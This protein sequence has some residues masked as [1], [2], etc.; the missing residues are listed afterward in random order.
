VLW[1]NRFEGM[2]IRCVRLV[3]YE[4]DGKVLLDIQQVLPLP[5]AA[6][7][8]VRLRRKDAARERAVSSDGRDFTRYHIVVDGQELPDEN[9]RNAVRVMIASLADRGVPLAEIA[10]V[11]PDRAFRL[12]PGLITDPAEARATLAQTHPGADVRRFFTDHPM[13]DPSTGQTYLLFKM[14][15]RNTE[16]TLTALSSAFPT[17]KVSYRPAEPTT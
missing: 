5:E 8:Q 7:Y 3:P 11:L 17:A 16:P 9:K 12:V 13:P 15:G 14:W 10:G 4:I 2:D 1:L 6:D